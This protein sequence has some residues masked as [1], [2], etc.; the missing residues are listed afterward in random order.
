MEKNNKFLTLI[1]LVALSACSTYKKPQYRDEESS[2]NFT[3]PSDKKIEKSFYLLGDGGYSN[4]GGT[5]EGLLA[6][7]TYL[8]SVKQVGNYTIFL[9]DNIYPDGM[10]EEGN[11]LRERGEYRVDAQ[12][13]AVEHYDGKIMFIPGNHDWY[14]E[15]IAGLKRERDYIEEQLD[16]DNIFHPKPG[17]GFESIEVSDKIQLI[18]V[19]SQWYLTNWDNHPT[20]NDNCEIKTREALFT[21]IESELKKNQTKMVV[22]A[23]HHPLY[24]NGVHGG[25][26]NFNQHLYPSQKKIP[27]P[28]LGSLAMLIRTSGGVSIQDTQN[29]RYKKL[30]NRLETIAKKWGN[31]VFV[32][33]HEHSL[34]YIE[35]D[36]IKQVVSGAGS[37]GTNVHLGKDGLFAYEGQ[38]FA[39][40]D[41]FEDGATWVSYYGS[42]G[43]NPKL[44]Y[45]HEVYEAPEP[46]NL[47]TLPQTFPNYVEASVYDPEETE[48]TEAYESVWGDRYRNIYG[49][50]V[51]AK[52]VDLDTLYGGMQ[53]M[54]TGG[55][56][57]TKSLRLKDPQGR[58][59]NMRAIKKSAVQFLQTVA[60]KD[61]S[62][63]SDFENTLAEDVIEDFYTSAH[64]YGFMVIPTLSEAAGV[65]HTN[66]KLFY[67]PKQRALGRYNNEYGDELYMI[68]ERP[69]EH[70]TGYE[71]FG[72]PNHDIES[73][74]GVYERLRRDEKY[75]LD[76]PSYIRARIF[77]MLVG[78]WD[79]HQDQWRWSE[80]EDEEGNHTFR[81]VPRDRDQVFSNFDG[82]FFATLR[83]L[84]GL[85]NQFAVYNGDIKDVEW[86][87]T[88]AIG[89]D[90]SLIQN[91]GREEW[92]KQ[93]KY[94][95][96]H[97][98]DDVIEEAFSK[99]PEETRGESSERIQKY[100]KERRGNLVDIVERYYKVM[101]KTSIVTG[102]DKDDFVEVIRKPDGFT[103][104]TIYR[105]KDGEKADIVNSRSYDPK[106]TNEIWLY[107]LDDDDVFEVTGEGKDPIMMRIV[108]GQN[109]DIYRIKNG[110]NLKVYDYKSKPNTI[111]S[112]DKAKLHLTDDYEVNIF[113]KDRKI[114]KTTRIIPA[115]GFNPDDGVKIGLRASYDI[116]GFQRNPFTT[117]HSISA[118]YYFATQSFDVHYEAQFANM[119]KS[120]NLLVGAHFTSPSFTRNFFGYG[121]E[122]YNPEDELG[123][124]Y[125]RIRLSRLGGEAGF[126]KESP[127]GSYF[128]YVASFEGVK[129]D[130]SDD[131]FISEAF[132]TDSDFFERKYFFGLEGIYRYESYD[133][134][135]NPSNGMKFQL[136][137]G[138]KMNTNDANKI[139]GYVEPYLGFYRSIT[140]NR[141]LVLN[142]RIQ[143]EVNV[144]DDFQF[145][146]AATL[147]GENGLRGFR[148][149]RFSGE[150]ALATGAD[151]R[152][153][154]EEFKTALLP[155]QIGVFAGYDVGRVWMGNEDSSVWH[156]SYGGGF[157]VTSAK[158]LSG[159]FNLF[160]GGE[161]L[162]FSFSFGFNF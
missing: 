58:D 38:G 68:V 79:R 67:V 5:S 104:I 114:Y 127:F 124:D 155:V 44:L 122:T 99:L 39:V 119:W 144:G 142:P 78:D 57:Q 136:K 149:N 107:G 55:G 20:V 61:A 89:L 66:P 9:G 146:Q 54:R 2:Q 110:E 117:R 41:V 93:A 121:N 23:I 128:K 116:Y 32:S 81:P 103:K 131:R 69:E 62:V 50:K 95:Q 143:A 64:P 48:K 100:L 60:F 113:D 109:N 19:D 15:G 86:F 108:G 96:E 74:D 157:W 77:D 106:F 52:V 158:A 148:T 59:Y 72:A 25:F 17:C 111:E 37:K 3:Y 156:D 88:A 45:R 18:V 159:R 8:D 46:V 71:S 24:T 145:Y 138:G 13:D 112:L 28:I 151:L 82:A 56:H 133:E 11:P 161:G 130:D 22:F 65:Y 26:Y 120:Y 63:T 31:V 16:D 51:K 140:R 70:Y 1:V 125:N 153:S 12:L 102:T 29:L 87:N 141:K 10:E 85:A 47:D 101:A 84:T 7:K 137:V 134:V 43:N 118:G 139:F 94:L 123:M 14:N 90:R 129:I 132:N 83:G 73:T 150:S 154:F 40:L 33:G 135:N 92:I 36:G 6:F 42:D 21:E 115:V 105:I 49:T 98:T 53:V 4:P 30:V 27:F 152:Y 75:K 35:K 162:R 91:E 97:V 76:E 160:S 147:G 126:V 80:F 34:Q